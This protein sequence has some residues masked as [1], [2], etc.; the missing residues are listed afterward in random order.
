METNQGAAMR[1]SGFISGQQRANLVMPQSR[2]QAQP[3]TRPMSRESNGERPVVR[4]KYFDFKP[5]QAPL[6]AVEQPVP[7]PEPMPVVAPEAATAQVA[8]A[9]SEQTKQ[10]VIEPAQSV[11]PTN[12]IPHVMHRTYGQNRRVDN[13]QRRGQ[14]KPYHKSLWHRLVQLMAVALFAVSIYFAVDGWVSSHGGQTQ[15]SAL[16]AA[17]HGTQQNDK[18]VASGAALSEK[19]PMGLGS[20]R[21]AG[22]LPRILHIPS[23]SAVSRVLH[24]GLAA[25][26]SLTAPNDIYDTGWY[27]ASAQPNDKTGAILINGHIEGPTKPGVFAGLGTLKPGEEIVLERGDRRMMTFVVSSVETLKNDEVD[28]KQLLKSADP[29]KLGL[30]LVTSADAVH[31]N[32]PR[33]V[34]HA[35]QK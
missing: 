4:T 7:P 23:L 6:K 32:Q 10:V 14:R 15:V 9:L 1:P 12:S 22:E 2:V 31:T 18:S 21:V 35:V 34:V 17:A 20:Y 19:R 30:N 3:A 24:L 25:D 8:A 11:E 13:R 27:N 26:G 5:S 28:M 33:V 29:N 16:S